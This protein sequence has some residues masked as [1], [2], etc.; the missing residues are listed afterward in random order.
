MAL[1][2]FYKEDITTA[3]TMVTLDEATS[4]HIVQVLRMQN[5]EPLQLTDGKGNL[6]TCKI[7]DNN[8]KHCS[9]IIEQTTNCQPPINNVSIAISLLK[10]TARFEW[11][12]EKAIEIGVTEIIPLVCDRTEKITFKFERLNSIVISAM[13]QSQQT[14]LPLLHQPQQLKNLTSKPFS[15]CTK[16]IAHCEE[17]E[18][19]NLVDKLTEQKKM[20]AAKILSSNVDS[21][22]VLILIGPEGDFTKIEIEAALKNGFTPVS[23]GNTRLRTET[24]GVAAAVLLV[25]R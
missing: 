18:K 20:S 22:Q 23:L 25:N 16:F 6:F 4:K 13:L 9:V 24:A 1:P 10:N 15:N 12:L 11:F 2:F 3:Q 14:W 19:I 17:S 5:G 7:S 8:R 21:A